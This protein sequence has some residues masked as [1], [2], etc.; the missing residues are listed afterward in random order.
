MRRR[1]LAASAALALC[2]V[3]LTAA[4]APGDRGCTTARGTATL[5][6]NKGNKPVGAYTQTV[7]YCWSWVGKP[8]QYT[9]DS[10][11]RSATW[12]LQKND[13]KCGA[14]VFSQWDGDPRRHYDAVK[15]WSEKTWD[16]TM[17]HTFTRNYFQQTYQN[18]HKCT[19]KYRGS[20]V[21]EPKVVLRLALPKPSVVSAEPVRPG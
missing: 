8:S 12:K 7:V 9:I 5:L 4:A 19:F 11:K 3:P 18:D 13:E 1:F 6:S 14:D 20:L 15:K 16:S 21:W 2:A 10:T 17:G